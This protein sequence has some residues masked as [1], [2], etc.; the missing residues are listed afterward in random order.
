VSRFPSIGAGSQHWIALCI[1]AL[2]IFGILITLKYTERANRHAAISRAFRRAIS[3]KVD[4]KEGNRIEDIYEDAV[5]KHAQRKG[6]TGLMH[7][8]Q[9]RWFWVALHCLVLVLG[10]TMLLI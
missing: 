7:N 2:G 6:I 9:A 10:A 5:S 4:D 3:E 1:I 8:I